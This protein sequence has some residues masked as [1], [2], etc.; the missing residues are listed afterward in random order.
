MSNTD[1]PWPVPHNWAWVRACRRPD[2]PA[3]PTPAPRRARSH[4]AG[5]ARS[6]APP[7]RRVRP[8]RQRRAFR[9]FA[10]SPGRPALL[11]GQFLA[12]RSAL[13]YLRESVDGG[14]DEFSKMQ[15]NRDSNS[16]TGSSSSAAFSATGAAFCAFDSATDPPLQRRPTAH[17]NTHAT[18]STRIARSAYGGV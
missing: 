8:T 4:I 2:F 5:T 9:S 15:P 6:D 3:L 1:S 16:V 13:P 11:T 17:P 14:I 12:V 7:Q 10:R 18:P